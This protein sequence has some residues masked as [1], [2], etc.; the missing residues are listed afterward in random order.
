[1]QASRDTTLPLSAGLIQGVYRGAI[2]MNRTFKATV[3]ALMLAV[4]FEPKKKRIKH[5]PLL[6][7]RT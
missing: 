3:A 7:S 2:G 5:S 1:V 4:S 6:K